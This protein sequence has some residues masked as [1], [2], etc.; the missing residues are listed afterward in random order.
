MLDPSRNVHAVI[1]NCML[2]FVT[3]MRYRTWPK[4][5]FSYRNSINESLV[6]PEIKEPEFYVAFRKLINTPKDPEIT[7]KSIKYVIVQSSTVRDLYDQANMFMNQTGFVDLEL[8]GFAKQTTSA[9]TGSEVVSLLKKNKQAH[10]LQKLRSTLA[11][12]YTSGISDKELQK[13]WDFEL[14]S[15]VQEK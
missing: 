5:H 14:V 7:F 9:K 10:L 13:I 8:C 11:E 3:I 12:C 2:V 6:Y 15:D 1:I 4:E